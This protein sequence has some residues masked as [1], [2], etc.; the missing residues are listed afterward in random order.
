MI[1]HAPLTASG[2][3]LPSSICCCAGYDINSRYIDCKSCFWERKS[4]E[5]EMILSSP[6]VLIRTKLLRLHARP[7]ANV[8]SSIVASFTWGQFLPNLL[9]ISRRPRPWQ[10][11]SRNCFQWLSSQTNKQYV[12]FVVFYDLVSELLSARSLFYKVWINKI[13]Q[14]RCVLNANRFHIRKRG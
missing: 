2:R 4:S 5:Q 12:V 11:T 1:T 9:R 8:R 7:K 14:R 10:I 3:L 6:F 13:K